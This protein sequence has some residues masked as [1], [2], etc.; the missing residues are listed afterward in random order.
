VLFLRGAFG[1]FDGARSAAVR[2]QI[3]VRASTLKVKASFDHEPP[4]LLT[5]FVLLLGQQSLDVLGPVLL[6]VFDRTF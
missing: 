3:A 6:V 5:R 2:F 4:A 1:F